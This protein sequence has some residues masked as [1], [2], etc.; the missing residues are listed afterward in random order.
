MEQGDHVRFGLIAGIGMELRRVVPARIEEAV[1]GMDGDM[2]RQDHEL[3]CV[4]ARLQ[5]PGEPGEARRV[6]P[7]TAIKRRGLIHFVRLAG[8]VEHDHLERQIGLRQEGITGGRAACGV[9]AEPMPRRRGGGVEKLADEVHGGRN[10]FREDVPV[11]V[12]GDFRGRFK[13]IRRA[14]LDHVAE[15]SGAIHGAHVHAR[16]FR[17]A[18]SQ[19]AM[20]GDVEDAAA[21]H[22]LLDFRGR[23]ADAHPELVVVADGRIPGNGAVQPRRSIRHLVIDGVGPAMGSGT[24]HDLFAVHHVDEPAEFVELGGIAEIAED[25]AEIE[26]GLAM[27]GVDG[28][29]GG[30]D[31]VGGVEHD[32]RIGGLVQPAGASFE[33]GRAPA[34]V[35][36]LGRGFLVGDVDVAHREE[37]QQPRRRGGVRDFGRRKELAALVRAGAPAPGP[38]AGGRILGDVRRRQ[39]RRAGRDVD[40]QDRPL[41][42]PPLGPV[43]GD[44]Q[45]NQNQQA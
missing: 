31:M 35:R 19:R 4:L 43:A 40:R 36:H 8:V 25:D 23:V 44:W 39:P 15:R 5:F 45:Q 34:D 12:G 10:L 22:G 33:E 29:D 9:G 24:G 21:D 11:R 20:G 17:A 7:A 28:L 41:A 30:I 16:T 1:L 2:G 27:Q 6:D 32:R 18:R 42:G 26:R 13:P 37:R 3:V 14:P 38:V